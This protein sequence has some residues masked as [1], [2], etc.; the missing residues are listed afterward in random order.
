VLHRPIREAIPELAGQGIYELLDRVFET[1]EPFVSRA[2]RL[3]VDSADGHPEDRFFDFC[4][5]PVPDSRGKVD[6]IL[7]VVFEVTELA[8][9]RRDADVA[10]RAKD[11]FFAILGHELRNPLAP[12]TTA[13]QVMRMRGDET[14]PK[15]LA[16]IERQVAQIT[17]LVDDLLDVSRIT[18]G[19]VVLKLAPIELSEVVS[20]AI[21]AASP[22]Y[23]RYRHH[24]ESNVAPKGLLVNGDAARLT[25]VVT[26][27]LT[28]A[29]KYT[30]PG[31][32]VSVSASASGGQA[33]LSVVDSGIGISREMLPRV[34]EPFS[35]ASQALDR[36][37]GGLG[38]GLT[39]VSNLVKLHG[40][41][42]E[43]HSE[44]EG[45]GSTF[46]IRLPL[47]SAPAPLTERDERQLVGP[48]SRAIRVLIVD[49]N[50]DGAE[51]LAEVLGGL[52]CE[53]RTAF[54]GVEGLRVNEAFKPQV[55]LLDLGL[56]VMDGYEVARRIR[57]EQRPGP[58]FLV[59][60]T[61][62]GTDSDRERVARSGFDA[63]LV[64]PVSF[65]LVVSLIDRFRS[66]GSLD[67]LAPT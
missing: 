21:E 7:V 9:A 61:G 42:A 41:T 8:K 19:K 4:Y 11:E 1:G 25:Q 59:A 47:S 66:V 22:L 15:E 6:S 12:I 23:E 39:V 13:L 50:T 35:Q 43:A 28:N 36:A 2:I 57:G 38:L 3:I 29:A 62:Y 30:E 17:R 5:Q 58:P 10:N 24:L 27:L 51:M 67:R 52:G 18:G 33:V 34:F 60:V 14:L 56:P 20:K 16:V 44:G 64:K 53:T 46:T 54:D 55:I 40:G 45:R 31:G 65:E 32:Q 48:K 63:H 37:Q 49:D 26:N